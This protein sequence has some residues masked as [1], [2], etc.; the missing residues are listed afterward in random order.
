MEF[1]R[2]EGFDF[3]IIKGGG[4]DGGLHTDGQF[5]RN[6]TRYTKIICYQIAV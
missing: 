1:A 4:G 6:K 5:A 3:V 2:A